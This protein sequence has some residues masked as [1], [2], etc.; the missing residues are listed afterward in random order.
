MI[1]SVNLARH[2]QQ[3][4]CQC[5]HAVVPR[6]FLHHVNKSITFLKLT[7]LQSLMAQA[8]YSQ[9]HCRVS[10]TWQLVPFSTLDLLLKL[11]QHRLPCLHLYWVLDFWA[12]SEPHVNIYSIS[13]FF[14]PVVQ[15]LPQACFKELWTLCST[16]AI[17]MPH[18]WT[19]FV[20]VGQL[21]VVT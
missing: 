16:Q 2:S 11:D 12:A 10:Q 21:S 1:F 6:I 17:L 3:Y 4:P 15:L 20:Y 19:S 13:G 5:L 8:E 14:W 18:F 7:I 9:A